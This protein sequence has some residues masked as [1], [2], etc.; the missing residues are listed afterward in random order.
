M[1]SKYDEIMVKIAEEHKTTGVPITQLCKKYKMPHGYYYN[2]LSAMNKMG[3]KSRAKASA[4][5]GA[6]RSKDVASRTRVPIGPEMVTIEIPLREVISAYQE[7]KDAVIIPRSRIFQAMKQ[8]DQDK[9]DGILGR[10]VRERAD[11]KAEKTRTVKTLPEDSSF[12]DG[13]EG[14]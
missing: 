5:N 3:K 9:F 1:P 4:T 13:E 7:G 2:R 12:S 11:K 8:E 14:H 10:L 6:D